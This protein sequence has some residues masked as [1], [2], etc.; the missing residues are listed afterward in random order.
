MNGFMAISF[1]EHGCTLLYSDRCHFMHQNELD[2]FLKQ[3]I[4]QKL[5]SVTLETMRVYLVAPRNQEW[6][7]NS[8]FTVTN[9]ICNVNRGRSINRL[10]EPLVLKMSVSPICELHSLL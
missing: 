9:E 5:M 2:S 10:L 8:V 7:I 6:Q 3:F 4:S 1:I